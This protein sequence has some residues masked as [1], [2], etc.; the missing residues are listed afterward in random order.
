MLDTI[1]TIVGF[2]TVSAGGKPSLSG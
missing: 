1:L 2:V